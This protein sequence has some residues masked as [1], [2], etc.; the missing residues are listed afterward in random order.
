MVYKAHKDSINYHTIKDKRIPRAFQRFR[1]FFI[2]DIHRR[3]INEETLR[4][5]DQEID[6]VV[7]GGDLLEKGVPFSR[8]RENIRKLKRVSESIYF[9]WGNNDLEVSIDELVK[10]LEG[11]GVCILSNSSINIMK[12]NS[13]LSLVGLEYNPYEEPNFTLASNKANGE[14]IILLTHR[15]GDFYHLDINSKDKIHMVLAGHTHGGQ[16]RFGPLGFYE[17]G[18]L[19][20]YRSSYVLVSEGYGYTK[21]PF[22]LGTKSECH[23]ITIEKDVKV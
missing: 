22:R 13:I 21:L 16:I 10:L 7:I 18:Y 14:Y 8:T 12:E 2:S 17:K 5:I 6:I 20:K 1:I 3:S 15:P 23:V 19:Q 4:D 9:I 11:E